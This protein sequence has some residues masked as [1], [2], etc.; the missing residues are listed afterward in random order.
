MEALEHA[1]SM[2]QKSCDA[3]V[4]VA[5]WRD[6]RQEATVSWNGLRWPSSKGNTPFDIASKCDTEC[7]WNVEPAA[8][9]WKS[10]KVETNTAV[11]A[12]QK[13][14][15]RVATIYVAKTG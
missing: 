13:S 15:E 3:R 14:R 2:T 4:R 5:Q 8:E 6:G 7:C 9:V 12:R 11:L 1:H 10:R